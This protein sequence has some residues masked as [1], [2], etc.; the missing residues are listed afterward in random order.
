VSDERLSDDEIVYRRILAK[1]VKQ[2]RIPKNQFKL[3]ANEA[4]ISVNRAS[5]ISRADVCAKGNPSFEYLLA[6]SSIGAIR[7]LSA[8][9]G[10][11]LQLDVIP[12]HVNEDPSHAEIRGPKTGE[13]PEGSHLALARLFQIDFPIPVGDK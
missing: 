9:D 8:E 11:W 10:T 12:T 13:L 7:Q 4:G 6:Q 3:R 5:L 2:N 1:D